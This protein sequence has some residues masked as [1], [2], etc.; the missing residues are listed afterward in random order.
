MKRLQA[1]KF[2]GKRFRRG[3]MKALDEL[4]L[5]ELARVDAYT[6]RTIGGV[7]VL[8]L[9]QLEA[10]AIPNAA[11]ETGGS[12]IA[13][14]PARNLVAGGGEPESDEDFALRW[15]TALCGIMGEDEVQR[16]YVALVERR[17]HDTTRSRGVS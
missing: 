9:D 15:H 12:K 1:A 10:V 11:K 8:G 16:V 7:L 5:R 2:G 3:A 13:K 4:Q 14:Y 17:L 6:A